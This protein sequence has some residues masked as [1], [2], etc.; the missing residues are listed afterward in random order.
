MYC[1]QCG[2]N[3]DGSTVFCTKCGLNLENLES[4]IVGGGKSSRRKGIEQGVKLI[5]FGVLLIPVWMF[6]GAA[7]PA[8]DRLVE[9]SP[10]NT[11][12]ESLAWIVMWMTFLAGSVRIAYTFAFGAG[13]KPVEAAGRDSDPSDSVREKGALPSAEEFQSARAGGWKTTGDLFE[14]V[15]RKARTSGEL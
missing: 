10:S 6:I 9:S 13:R 7:F 15:R 12:A 4:F 8:N 14:P 11:W 1:P 3:A 2:E 5:A